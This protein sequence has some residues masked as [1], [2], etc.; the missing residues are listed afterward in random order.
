MKVYKHPFE[1]D[2]E[3]LAKKYIDEII[4]Q[5]LS[6]RP[7]GYYNPFIHILTMKN[8]KVYTNGGIVR[9][10]SIIINICLLSNSS[11]F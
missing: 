7:K 11:T 5:G 8:N 6:D 9:E 1:P 3:V 2:R 4:R 10:F